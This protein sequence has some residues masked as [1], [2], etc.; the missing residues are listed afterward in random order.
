MLTT[1]PDVVRCFA[2]VSLTFHVMHINS[3]VR[4]VGG[5]ACSVAC[6]PFAYV[7]R[8]NSVQQAMRA[9]AQFIIQ[10]TCYQTNV[11]GMMLLCVLRIS[12]KTFV[13]QYANKRES[14]HIVVFV[15]LFCVYTTSRFPLTVGQ[16]Q[17]DGTES[18]CDNSSWYN[19]RNALHIQSFLYV[20]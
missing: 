2:R 13:S 10:R 5:R 12:S 17:M 19:F 1:Q 18:P 16:C 11:D 4:F 6:A 7:V 8:G 9:L 14:Y 15:Y 3:S 20:R